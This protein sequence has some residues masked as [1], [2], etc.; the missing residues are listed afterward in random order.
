MDAAVSIFDKYRQNGEVIDRLMKILRFE[1]GIN[2]QTDNLK[3][4]C[5]DTIQV[6]EQV[7]CTQVCKSKII[8]LA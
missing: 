5:L 8:K 1:P 4:R 7:V 6:I 2:A 3:H